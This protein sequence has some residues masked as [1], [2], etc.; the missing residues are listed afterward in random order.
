MLK[1]RLKGLDI[2]LN[3]NQDYNFSRYMELFL[4]KN[5]KLNLISK[6]DEK[7]LF[8]KHIYDS[9]SLNLFLKNKKFETLLDIGTGGGFPSLPLAILYDDLQITA[10]DSIRKKINVVSEI[11]Q[12]LNLKNLT[13]ICDRVENIDKKYDIVVSRAVASLEKILDLA[14]PKVKCGGYFIAYKSKK[15]TE[16]LLN[17]KKIISKYKLKN[18]QIIEYKLPLD[19]IYE[20]YLVIFKV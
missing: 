8:E 7:F 16:E 19:E 17:A 18:P 14:I 12:E 1:S 4:E 20:R 13:L 5:S 11:S 15:Y 2:A 9:L 3:D 6:N 10:I